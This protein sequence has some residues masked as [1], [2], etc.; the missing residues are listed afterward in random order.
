MPRVLVAP[1]TL[2]GIE[3][4]FI[5]ALKSAGFELV[6]PTV[7]IQLNEEQILDHLKGVVAS[8]AGSEPYTRR[9][10]AAQSAVAGDL[11]GR[12]RVGRGRLRG[13]DRSWRGRHDH[14]EHESRRRRRAYVHADPGAGEGPH[15]P[16]SGHGRTANGRG[17]RICRF[18]DGRSASP[19][20][21]ASA[22]RSHCEASASA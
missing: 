4:P 22:R 8:L 12:R 10:L 3:S 19:G 7:K 2:A 16:A 14:A 20:S 15:Q 1:T 21:A 11:P 17:R 13:G 5:G 18:A 9:V 6:Y